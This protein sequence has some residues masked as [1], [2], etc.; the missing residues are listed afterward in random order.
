MP[1]SKGNRRPDDWLRAIFRSRVSVFR[2]GCRCRE[3]PD[4]NLVLKTCTWDPM[5]E[6]RDPRMR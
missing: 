1:N 5:A 4:P 6:T 3:I 2:F